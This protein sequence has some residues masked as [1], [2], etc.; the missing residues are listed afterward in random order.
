MKKPRVLIGS[1][2]IAEKKYKR[3]CLDDYLNTLSELTYPDKK[4]SL[5]LNGQGG[6]RLID[7]YPALNIKR[8]PTLDSP[9][10]TVVKARNI[11]REEVL[12]NGFDYLLFLE[13]DIIPHHAIV[14]NLLRHG[15]R[16][17]SALYFNMLKK[18]E[19][20]HGITRERQYYPMLWSFDA[21][22]L[23]QGEYRENVMSFEEIFP[24]RLMKVDVCGLG[25]VLIH[26][27]VL[28]K[29]P[30]RFVRN[31]PVFEE[32]YFG[33]DCREAGMDIFVDTSV[34]CRHY[35]TRNL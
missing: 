32:F 12:S 3:Y 9:V 21:D 26:R 27:D 18:G 7:Q 4:I 6:D 5:L 23:N 10:E 31:Q 8:S 11:L 28:E 22:R 24:S 2:I 15:K 29:V 33:R 19:R 14:E 30:F 20:K 13:Q 17:C 34:V 16:I 35:V 25:S 1:P